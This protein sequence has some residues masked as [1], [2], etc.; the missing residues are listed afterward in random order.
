MEFERRGN[1]TVSLT[2]RQ[3]CHQIVIQ[4]MI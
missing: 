4:I 3:T 1:Y 2:C